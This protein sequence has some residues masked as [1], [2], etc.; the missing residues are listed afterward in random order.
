MTDKL[1]RYAQGLIESGTTGINEFM[2]IRLRHTAPTSCVSHFAI[3]LRRD[4]R[5]DLALA[6]ARSRR[7]SARCLRQ[8]SQR[9]PSPRGLRVRPP[10]STAY[11]R[12]S[13][14][15]RVAL[16]DVLHHPFSRHQA[17]QNKDQPRGLPPLSPASTPET[18]N[19]CACKSATASFRTCR[20]FP[21]RTSD[22]RSAPQRPRFC[23]IRGLARRQL[24]SKASVVPP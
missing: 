13:G 9:P 7:R 22:I 11:R 16:P 12:G 17:P 20:R 2:L 14:C 3:C 10:S 5:L 1:K 6:T 19:I 15:H 21:C 8:P 4:Q 23:T 24:R 18:G